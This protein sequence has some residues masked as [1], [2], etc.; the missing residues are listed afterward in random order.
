MHVTSAQ[1]SMAPQREDTFL[2]RSTRKQTRWGKVRGWHT[3]SMGCW[4]S[5]WSEY[6]KAAELAGKPVNGWIREWL[7]EAV[8]FEHIRQRELADTSDLRR[9]F[10]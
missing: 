3:H 6:R 4:D 5:E 9:G 7:N 1:S 10:S 2:P 8:K